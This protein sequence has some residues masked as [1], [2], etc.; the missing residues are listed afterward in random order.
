M[1]T[2]HVGITQLYTQAPKRIRYVVTRAV[3]TSKRNSQFFARGT[4][5]K[6]APQHVR[7]HFNLTDLDTHAMYESKKTKIKNGGKAKQT[8]NQ[9][10]RTR[11]SLTSK[12]SIARE[13]MYIKSQP[14]PL[15]NRNRVV[16]AA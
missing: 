13:I 11:Y 2:E 5:T 12:N 7:S 16:H 10:N 14:K 8:N 6:R 9:K 4:G 1:C 3:D 15:R